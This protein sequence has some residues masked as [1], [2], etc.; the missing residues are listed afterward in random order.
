METIDQIYQKVVEMELPPGAHAEVNELIA[1]ALRAGATWALPA[2]SL[3]GYSNLTAAISAGEP[4]DYEKLDGRNVQC[5]NP[6]VGTNRGNMDR[7]TR[8]LTY[9]AKGWWSSEMD[10]VYIE[11]FC[12]AW[13]GRSGWTLWVEGEIPLIRKTAD[14]LEVGHF[15]TGKLSGTSSENLMCVAG[16]IC[17]GKHIRYASDFMPSQHPAE[18]WEVIEEHGTFQKPEG[19]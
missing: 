9:E 10:D 12:S 14:Q 19:E 16:G 1:T 4:I 3:E 15:F 18:K 6:N 11:A 5:V 7:D 8:Y 2:N 13:E 17:H